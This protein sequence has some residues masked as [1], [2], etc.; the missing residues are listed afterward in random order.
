ML[1]ED[2][3]DVATPEGV[4]LQFTLAGVGSR[5]VA[6]LIDTTIQFAVFGAMLLLAFV[7]RGLGPVVTAL[8][9]VLGFLVF[10]GYDIMF[11]TL[12]SGRTPGKRWTGLRVVKEGG[13]PVTFLTSAVRNVLR[14]VDILPTS[15]IVGIVCVLASSKNQRLGD[16]AAGT[17]VVRERK[18]S[19]EGDSWSLPVATSA[20]VDVDTWDV[21]G[22]TADEMAA[23]R[24]FMDRRPTLTPDAR[25]RIGRELA[26]RLWP[27][28]VGP[29]ESMGAEA[30][31]EALLAAKATRA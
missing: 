25:T 30:F 27:K 9:V 2:R 10:L 17:L 15:Y 1:Y 21:S 28:V 6:A 26:V 23:V 5:F 11:E 3:V 24:Q 4:T 16:M 20:R 8:V 12:A 7:V 22:V 29:A 14:L 31:L 18:A 13:A 19:I